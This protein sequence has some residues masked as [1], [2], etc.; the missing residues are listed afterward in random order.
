MIVWQHKES[1]HVIFQFNEPYA[2]RYAYISDW[3][4]DKMSGGKI[5]VVPHIVNLPKTQKSNFKDRYNINFDNI[6][7]TF[8]DTLTNIYS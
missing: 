1:A 2:D 6:H 3:L 7:Y 8:K 5:P 4:S